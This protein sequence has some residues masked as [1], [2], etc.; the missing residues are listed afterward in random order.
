MVTASLRQAKR[1][2]LEMEEVLEE[3]SAE[4]GV[5]PRRIMLHNRALPKAREMEDLR[6]RIDSL[7]KENA[8]LKTQVVDQDAKVKEA[9][10]LTAAAFKEKVRAKK[11]REKAVTMAKKF[12]AFVGFAGDVVTKAR[13]YDQCMKKPEVVPAPKIL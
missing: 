7:L 6:A 12:H 3:I 8:K 5:E 9:E 1:Q 2:Y 4:L 10:A 11:E 13:L